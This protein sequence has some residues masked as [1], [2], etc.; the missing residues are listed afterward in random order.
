M[1]CV[2]IYVYVIQYIYFLKPDCYKEYLVEVV[3]QFF[4]YILREQ[5]NNFTWQVDTH[6]VLPQKNTHN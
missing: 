6:M 1:P 2:K 4:K 3:S 5:M